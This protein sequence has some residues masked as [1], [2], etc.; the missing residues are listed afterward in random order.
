[1]PAKEDFFC[2]IV[3]RM[4]DFENV[5]PEKGRLKSFLRLRNAGWSD[6]FQEALTRPAYWMVAVSNL[7]V[8]FLPGLD[9]KEDALSFLWIYM[10]QS[11]LIGVVHMVKLNVYKF[12]E[13]QRPADWKS[14]RALSLFFIVH[15]GF[16][17]FVYAFFIPPENL[18]WPLVWEGTLIF[19]MALLWNT[20]RNYSIEN[21]GNYNANDF[22]F[23]PYV[24][25]IP[26]HIAI[27]IGGFLSAVAGS[28]A[29]VFII[30]ALIK[31]FMELGLEYFQHLGIYF[32]ELQEFKNNQTNEAG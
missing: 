30:L 5:A 3:Y 11:L 26:I 7:A 28:F 31:T 1:M 18:N 19:S 9:L 6:F 16:F 14:P 23:L 13:A 27:I 17:H 20:F 32:A 15:Y 2:K 24:R 21:S 25:I 8:F 4:T 10:M 29:P 22:M 12:S